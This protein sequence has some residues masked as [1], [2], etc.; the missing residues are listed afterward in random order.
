MSVEIKVPTLG[1]S[2][3]EATV[4]KW[5]KAQG[6]AVAA[7]EPLVELETDKVTV[8]VNAPVSG[9]VAEITVAEGNEVEVGA[10]LGFMEE[11][12]APAAAPQEQ[13]GAPAEAPA[14]ARGGNGAAAPR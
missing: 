13:A 11:G 5:F 2:V 3:T 12:D 10:L 6:E 8:E 4:A 14:A 7:D 1:E 9:T